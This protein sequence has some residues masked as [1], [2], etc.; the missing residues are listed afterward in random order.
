MRESL[1]LYVS[2]VLLLEPFHWVQW[3]SSWMDLSGR[4]ML[5]H[6]ELALSGV[7]QLV[8]LLDVNNSGRIQPWKMECFQF[9]VAVQGEVTPCHLIVLFSSPS[10]FH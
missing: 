1:L 2:S 8:I 3:D 9:P 5:E 7:G 4:L 10:F 6:I